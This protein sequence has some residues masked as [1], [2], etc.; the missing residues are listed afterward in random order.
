MIEVEGHSLSDSVSSISRAELSLIKHVMNPS[1]EAKLIA[2][3]IVFALGTA[4]K[5]KPNEDYLQFMKLLGKSAQ[6]MKR[7]KE[8]DPST[9]DEER[10]G[11]LSNYIKV[12][13]IGGE[14]VTKKARECSGGMAKMQRW[15][16][17][18]DEVKKVK[19]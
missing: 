1:P 16:L 19:A 9:I 7:M 11:Y 17:T 18:L 8:Y 14:E 6:M 10:A 13:N 4:T 15:L 2:A 5:I 3:G 12:N